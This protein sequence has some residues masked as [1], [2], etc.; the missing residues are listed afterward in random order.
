MA[1]ML[2]SVV[3]SMSQ[4]RSLW[5][6]AFSINCSTCT[7]CMNICKHM[8]KEVYKSNNNIYAGQLMMS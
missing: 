6:T 8:G 7:S 4:G 3:S 5:A 2:D 1:E